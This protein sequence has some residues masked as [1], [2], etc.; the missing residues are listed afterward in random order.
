MAMSKKIGIFIY[1]F[2][3]FFGPKIGTYLDTSIIA[4][5]IMIFISATRNDHKIRIPKY[6]RALIS[7]IILILVY[8]VFVSLYNS[9]FDITYY[10]R[11]IRSMFSVISI[12]SFLLD[13]EKADIDELNEIIIWALLI[14]AAIV[15]VSATV[16][17]NLQYMLRSFNGYNKTIRMFR[18]TGLMMGFDMSGLLCNLGLVLVMCKKRLNFFQFAVFAL[19]T[20]FTSRFS[21]LFLVV[22]TLIYIIVNLRN[23]ESRGKKTLLL[24]IGIPSAIFGI[25]LL[26]ITT[27]SFYSAR[28]GISNLFPRFY[29]LALR[30]NRA[31]NVTDSLEFA[32]SNHFSISDDGF[33]AAFGTGVYGGADP[34]YTRFINCIGIVGLALVII[35]HIY[36][37]CNSV[38]SNLI[39]KR[40]KY[41]RA[42]IVFSIAMVLIGLSFKNS[43]FFTG[44]FFEF[45]MLQLFM[46]KFSNQ[47]NET[48]IK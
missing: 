19:A 3:M 31:Y 38:N 5:I 15:L 34:G 17:V 40:L 45:M 10:G 32:E 37:I 27:R 21:I 47:Y 7:S 26:I 4:S 22:I 35:W 42:F 8:S 24:G 13:N 44:T 36:A 46:F 48:I 30:V 14:H 25:V 12:S 18:S 9:H 1:I 23:S 41:N 39:N 29:N 28:S 6:T 20:L 11:T 33:L 16:Y 43:Y 2:F